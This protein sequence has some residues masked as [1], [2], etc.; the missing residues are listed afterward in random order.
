MK[1]KDLPDGSKP[2]ERMLKHGASGLSDAE[3]LAIILRTG[4]INENVVDMS[5]RL[6]AEHG[7]HKIFECS[8]TEL[9]EFKGIGP[10]KAM[11]LLAMAEIGKRHSASKNPIKRIGARNGII[12]PAQKL[13]PPASLTS[14][15][16]AFNFVCSTP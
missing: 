16:T 5:N 1:I 15:V 6:I 4:T 2:R 3:L 8:L 13:K 9:Q 7:L 12:T 14:I 10:S 11:Q